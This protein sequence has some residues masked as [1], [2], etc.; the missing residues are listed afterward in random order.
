VPP[1][2]ICCSSEGIQRESTQAA[3][4]KLDIDFPSVWRDRER[5][6]KQAIFPT[7]RAH[8]QTHKADVCLDKH[9]SAAILIDCTEAIYFVLSEAAR[10][11]TGEVEERRI[12]F[13]CS[14]VHS[15]LISNHSK[16]KHFT[17]CQTPR[18][19]AVASAGKMLKG[20]RNKNKMPV[21]APLSRAHSI[22]Q[23][24]K[25][26]HRERATRRD[27]ERAQLKKMEGGGAQSPRLT[28]TLLLFAETLSCK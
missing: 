17:F 13:S 21:S 4:Q 24:S 20:Q 14:L 18:L 22:G 3:L 10:L 15:I 16:R 6:R 28:H 12:S 26:I 19:A 1:T 23:N 2:L 9:Y 11:L 7:K 27:I 25:F 5:V 8:T